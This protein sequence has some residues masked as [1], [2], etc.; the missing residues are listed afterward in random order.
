MCEC[1]Y[2][3]HVISTTLFPWNPFEKS[4]VEAEKSRLI[5][6]LGTEEM[7]KSWVPSLPPLIELRG[8]GVSC[9]IRQSNRCLPSYFLLVVMTLRQLFPTVLSVG[10]LWRCDCPPRL[11]IFSECHGLPSHLSCPLANFVATLAHL[12]VRL[13]GKLASNMLLSYYCYLQKPR[14]N[15]KPVLIVI[16]SANSS[17]CTFSEFERRWELWIQ[18][19]V[20]HHFNV[21]MVA[22]WLC[23]SWNFMMFQMKCQ[24]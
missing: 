3:L 10:S 14:Q 2:L 22:T 5:K 8:L 17:P 11:A 4:Q 1:N 12:V 13:A 7:E 19:T 18:L 9:Y 24:K 16:Y 21:V 15:M 23:F 20:V 6:C